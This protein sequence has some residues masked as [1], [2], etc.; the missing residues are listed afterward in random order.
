[1]ATEILLAS[2]KAVTALIDIKLFDN[3]RILEGF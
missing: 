2:V 1:M 3:E